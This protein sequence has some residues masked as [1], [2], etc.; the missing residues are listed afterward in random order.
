MAILTKGTTFAASQQVTSTNLNALVDSAAFVAGSSGTTDDST[1]EVS[2]SGRLQVKDGGVTAAKLATVNSNVGTYGTA[3]AVGSFTV[4]A[5]GQITAASAITI[6]PAVGSITGLGTGVATALGVNV[7]SAG[8]LVTNGGALGTPTSGVLTNC[9]GLPTVGIVDGAVTPAK[10]STGAPTWDGV[11]KATLSFSDKSSTFEVINTT[12]A[13]NKFPGFT[14]YNYNNGQ[15]GYPLLS[16]SSANGTLASPTAIT[17]GDTIGRVLFSS[18]NG[19]SF[20]QVAHISAIASETHS[21]S[22]E[23]TVMAFNSTINGATSSA[24][25]MRISETGGLLVGTATDVPSAILALSS[26]TRGFRLPVMTTA[27]RDAISAPA[28]G[29]MIFNTTTNKLNFYT[30]AAWEAVTSA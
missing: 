9:T 30:G 8:A 27:Q 7:G 28:E 19:S 12:S 22:A 24:E 25:R 29:I 13:T 23:G 10:L 3:T 26:T 21:G 6:T 2:G 11:N 15:S 14:S 1:L 18:H 4:T 16:L 5:A 20:E 17:S